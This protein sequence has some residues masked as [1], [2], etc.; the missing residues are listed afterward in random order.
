MKIGVQFITILLLLWSMGVHAQTASSGY[1]TIYYPMEDNVQMVEIRIRINLSE[2]SAFDYNSPLPNHV[3]PHPAIYIFRDA[4]GKIIKSYNSCGY[5]PH[6]FD[7][8][9]PQQVPLENMTAHKMERYRIVQNCKKSSQ[10]NGKRYGNL[11]LT[12]AKYGLIDRKGKV[13]IPPIYS[14]IQYSPSLKMI[15][16]K[17]N[18]KFGILNDEGKVIQP[19]RY[20][21][22]ILFLSNYEP[23]VA[24]KNEKF[25]YIDRKGQIISQRPYDYADKF[26]NK[27]AIVKIDE[28][29]GYIDSTGT[30][31]IPLKYD[32][33]TPFYHNTAVV[34]IG[35]KYGFI[36]H[37]GEIIQPIKYDKIEPVLTSF[38]LTRFIGKIGYRGFI[39]GKETR[40]NANG[41]QQ[42][43]HDVLYL[44]NSMDSILLSPIVLDANVTFCTEPSVMKEMQID[45][46]GDK[47]IIISRM[48]QSVVN[49]AYGP[50]KTYEIER[51]EVWNQDEKKLLFEAQ[52]YYRIIN[53]RSPP[54]TN[55]E[56]Y[57]Y[58]FTIDNQG[59][60]T[61][62]NA[63]TLPYFRPLDKDF[64]DKSSHAVQPDHAE[65]IFRFENG[66]Y[67]KK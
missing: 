22:P 59:E 4:K 41:S 16:A 48:C 40:F 62:S 10:N 53:M 49:D 8:V 21:E 5:S 12:K 60:I 29:F 26:W 44:K 45:G 19:F 66:K 46:T 33:A 67:K 14:D 1:E 23:V 42:Q 35:G 6:H 39:S 28:K 61:I 20:D 18:K 51:I 58:S 50:C 64:V 52:N 13:V 38:T 47:E 65:G 17:K 57:K 24:K 15:V 25:V 63:V 34:G 55:N 56:G 9:P 37:Q 2:L 27:R 54:S 3:R 7:L 11:D 32:R 43:R 36:N 31:V 30:E